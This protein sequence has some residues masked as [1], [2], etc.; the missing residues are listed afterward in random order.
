[1][2]NPYTPHV[3]AITEKLERERETV[4]D[5]KLKGKHLSI[6]R[7]LL[8]QEIQNSGGCTKCP[9]LVEIDAILYRARQLI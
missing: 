3:E 1:M 4:V 2:D 5:V 6:L 8:F 7:N 9:D